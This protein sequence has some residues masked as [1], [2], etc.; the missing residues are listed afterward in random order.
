MAKVV[1]E[2]SHGWLFPHQLAEQFSQRRG[3]IEPT[4]LA[5]RPILS[6]LRVS[7]VVPIVVPVLVQHDGP[8]ELLLILATLATS[9]A[10]TLTTP[11]RLMRV[12]GLL[13]T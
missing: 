6:A 10:G 5:K 12:P 1:E 4:H 3:F 9:S 13:I 8:V 7:L 11:V 2:P